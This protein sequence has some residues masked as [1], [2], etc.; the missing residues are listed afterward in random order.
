MGLDMWFREDVSRI[1]SSVA[2]TM[3]STIDAVVPLKVERSEA[4]RAGFYDALRA[5]AVA[6]G[7]PA[8]IA[9]TEQ[10]RIKYEIEGEWKNHDR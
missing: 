1:L 6:F 5:L 10:E 9:P 8:P 2:V 4:Y 3:T 7:V